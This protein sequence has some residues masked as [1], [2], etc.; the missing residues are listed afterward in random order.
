VPRRSYSSDSEDFDPNQFLT[1]AQEATER[2]AF[3][4]PLLAAGSGFGPLGRRSVPADYGATATDDEGN[5]LTSYP[6]PPQPLNQMPLE[7]QMAWH[8]QQIDDLG[9]Q[10]TQ[11]STLLTQRIN[12]KNL[13]DEN[14]KQRQLHDIADSLADLDPHDLDNYDDKKSKILAR[15][16]HAAGSTEANALFASHDNVYKNVR[17][18]KD[19][20]DKKTAD[21]YNQQ[22]TT[23][24]S[25]ISTK[26]PEL[27]GPFNQM[28][29]NHPE[30]A[31]QFGAEQITERETGNTRAQLEDHFSP[32]EIQARFTDPK[33]NLLI[34]KANA[35]IKVKEGQNARQDA[36]DD[37]L[38]K[39]ISSM[40]AQ[41]DAVQQKEAQSIPGI[42]AGAATQNIAKLTA[43]LADSKISESAKADIQKQLAQEQATVGAFKSAWTPERDDVLNQLR[44]EV[45]TR[46]IGRKIAKQR[47][48]SGEAGTVNINTGL[49]VPPPLTVPVAPP[50]SLTLGS[51]L[52]TLAPGPGAVPATPAAPVVPAVPVVP[53]RSAPVAVAGFPATPYGVTQTAAVAGQAAPA[54]P[55]VDQRVPHRLPDGR[56]AVP[57]PG[58]KWGVKRET[59]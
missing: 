57:L 29:A 47:A 8:N 15:N 25:T 49:V 11:K 44:E 56:I 39:M 59:K 14:E 43:Q 1:A 53:Q 45:G 42:M 34:P 35:A 22:V 19:A 27:A 2:S 26:Y 10:L 4:N 52:P 55:A 21:T 54:A 37:R 31:L 5:V 33:G 9:K 32:E 48:L 20:A 30:Q 51:T 13:A 6:I 50:G 58:N 40:E 18:I 23:M 24:L 36:E 16:A 3:Q 46:V 12:A 7:Q 17:G 38:L 28:L 41:R